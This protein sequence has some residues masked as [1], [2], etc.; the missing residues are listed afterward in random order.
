MTSKI[1]VSLYGLNAFVVR[2]NLDGVTHEESLRSAGKGGNCI[3][4][5]MA[6]IVATRSG[7]LRLAGEEPVG[8]DD[9]MRRYTRGSAPL[10]NGEEAIPLDRLC[11][12][13]GLSQVKLMEAL[14]RLSD[15]DLASKGMKGGI[16][17][18]SIGE[19]LAGLA[20]HEAYHAGQL[21][22]LRRLAGREGAIP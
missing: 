9:A 17:G 11:A 14:V 7:V 4:W 16:G 5:V 12:D 3:N 6:H 2:E 19:Q 18:E 21:G 15:E 10:R 20:F 1:L 22:I 13:F 8:P